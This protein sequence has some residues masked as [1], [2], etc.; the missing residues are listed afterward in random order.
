MAKTGTGIDFGSSGVTAVSG[1]MKGGAFQLTRAWRNRFDSDAKTGE[2]SDAVEQAQELLADLKAPGSI[3]GI[4]GRDVMLRYTKAPAM[5]LF[6]LKN[7]MTFEVDEIAE[8][9]GGDVASDYS[10]LR[11]DE[12]G[13]GE[14]T[15]LVGLAKNRYLSPRLD[16]LKEIGSKV[17]YACPVPLALFNAH[18]QFG[19]FR[20]G[21]TTLLLDIGSENLDMAIQSDGELLFARSMSLGGKSFTE[22]VMGVMNSDFQ[23]AEALKCTKADV[24][25]G[26]GPLDA[27]A[28]KISNGMAGVCGQLLSAIQSSVLFCRNQTGASDVKLDRV[29]LAGGGGGLRGLPEFLQANLEIPVALFEFSTGLDDSGLDDEDRDL[30]ESEAHAFA[31]AVGLAHMAVADGSF[32]LEITPEAE[33]KKKALVERTLFLGLAGVF[34]LG[35]LGWRGWVGSQNLEEMKS[36]QKKLRSIE[37]TRTS[38]A[39]KFESLSTEVK[40]LAEKLEVVADLANPGT[41][42]GR[43]LEVV[44]THLPSDLWVRNIEV[45]FENVA[46]TKTESDDEEE[47]EG[48]RRRSRSSRNRSKA[49]AKDV[50]TVRLPVVRVAGEGKESVDD[51]QKIVNGFARSVRTDPSVYDSTLKYSSK[52][53]SFEV[54]IVFFSVGGEEEADGAGGDEGDEEGTNR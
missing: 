1:R 47:D 16:A 52:T 4:T 53:R 9:A 41:A 14:A 37:K 6:Q 25:R 15:I 38:N 10:I 3:L 36:R 45:R 24:S 28:E 50:E 51:V 32:R 2:V 8:K 46:R 23:K 31:V 40:S 44:Q 54:E 49:D 26:S 11:V 19:D 22:G 42:L 39:E 29:I 30:L 27:T 43:G 34:A 7:L 21:E 33:K 13:D 5:S 20:R 48:R 18:L 12:E 17:S 35:F